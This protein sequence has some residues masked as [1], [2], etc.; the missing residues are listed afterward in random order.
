MVTRY[1]AILDDAIDFMYMGH[2]HVHASIPANYKQVF[3]NGAIESS[4]TFVRKELM[5]ANPPSQS[6]VFYDPELGPISEH[7]FYLCDRVPS[8]TRV[9]SALKNRGIIQ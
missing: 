4:T 2:I 8:G 7:T 9:M 5:S 3:V 6:A 1:D